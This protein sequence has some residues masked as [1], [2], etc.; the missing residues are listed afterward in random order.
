MQ[1]LRQSE[2]FASKD[3]LILYQAFTNVN[4]NASDPTSIN[5]AL[6]EYIANNFPED[7]NDW[8]ESSEFVAI[9]DLLSWL[10]GTL[11][12]KM[13]INAREN[14][15]ETAESRES[16]LRLARFLSYTPR[17]NRP[18]TGLVKLVEVST[19]DLIEDSTGANLSGVRVQWNNPDDPDWFER[20]TAI[21]SNAFVSTNQFGTP[22]KSGVVSGTRTHLYRVNCIQGNNNFS[23]NS[24]VNGEVMDFDLCNGDFADQGPFFERTP[25]KSG[26]F[27]LFYRNDGNGNA[28]TRTGFFMLFKQ[29]T[30]VEQNF[31][32]DFPVENQV[33]DLSVAGVN[34]EDV[35]VQTVTDNGQIV[36]NW[37]KVP[38][39]ILSFEGF[40][41][42]RRYILRID[43]C[44]KPAIKRL[45]IREC[46]RC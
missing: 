24:S 3:W 41:D 26:A 30:L 37:S 38:A 5:R 23:F 11:A 36:I 39:S 35:W 32:I 33:L 16:V 44:L 12:F 2:L 31:R 4:F 14:F 22:L 19:D 40:V 29:G 17:R 21:L 8:I 10:A 27:N 20:F 25:D 28:S 7:L 43:F 34:E 1:S 18:A 42:H 45:R 15:L 9:I 13:D 46:R 6:R